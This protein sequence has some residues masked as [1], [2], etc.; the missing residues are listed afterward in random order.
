VASISPAPT[1]SSPAPTSASDALTHS[2]RYFARWLNGIHYGLH[3]EPESLAEQFEIADLVVR[4]PIADLYIGEYWLSHPEEQPYPLAYIR[5]DVQEVLKGEP[6]SR[7]GGDVEVQV[8]SAGSDLETIRAALPTH[9]N[10]WFLMGPSGYEGRD[11]PPQSESEI[12]PYAFVTTNDYQGILR[13][14]D[15]TVQVVAPGALNALYGPDYFPSALDGTSFQSLLEKV[16]EISGPTASVRPS[17]AS[18]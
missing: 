10:L 15:G 6:V 13:N 12:A 2:S 17:A 9:D 3:Y 1:P 18:P 4:G 16:R 5:I 11:W 8:G 7:T 14:I